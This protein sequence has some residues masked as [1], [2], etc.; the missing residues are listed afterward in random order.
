VTIFSGVNVL[1]LLPR[2]FKDYAKDNHFLTRMF[3]LTT[4]PPSAFLNVRKIILLVK[5]RP[6]TQLVFQRL[7]K[8]YNLATGFEETRIKGA[9]VE[10]GVWNGGSAAVMAYAGRNNNERQVWL[11]DSWEGLPKPKEVDKT[12]LG[13]KGKKGMSIGSEQVVRHLLFKVL[14]LRFIH[15]V[16]GWFDKTLSANKREVGGIVLLHLDCDW[17]ESVKCC[18]EEL[19]DQVVDGG[20][21]VI[22][23]YGQWQGCKQAVD[24]FMKARE[25]TAPLEQIDSTGVYFIKK[26]AVGE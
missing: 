20:V 4:V 26:M 21:V 13:V 17:Y 15:L 7:S 5:I 22:D 24:E 1:A 8:L 9:F 6:Y 11:F 16:K 12:T 23:D 2:G 14:G 10:C 18:L 19:Y 25:I 3:F